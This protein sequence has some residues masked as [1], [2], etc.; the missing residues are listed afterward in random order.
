VAALAIGWGASQTLRGIEEARST[1]TERGVP[2][3]LTLRDLGHRLRQQVPANEVVMSNLGPML[4][5]YSG[6]SVVHLAQTP[7]DLAACR[8]RL[9]FRH[10]LVV[11][12]DVEAAWPG[13]EDVFTR[14]EEAT[15]QPEWNVVRE[16][17]WRQH[18]G[19]R[20]VWL[21]L[22]PP[23]ASLARGGWSGLEAATGRTPSSSP[24]ALAP[25]D[26]RRTGRP[27]S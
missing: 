2:S 10:V 4:S 25:S 11:F 13:W 5:W 14:P 16:R 15:K 24:T 27:R 1:S 6:R 18:D 17:H 23:E 19:F 20:I 12:R 21:E 8:R 22:G 7:A 3:V 9:E 26:A